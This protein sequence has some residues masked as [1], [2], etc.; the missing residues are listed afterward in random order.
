[1]RTYL[2]AALGFAVL[3]TSVLH[4]KE[5]YDFRTH[6]AYQAL[7]PEE[8]KALEQVHHDFALLWGAIDMYTEQNGGRSPEKLEQLVPLY[9]RELPTDPFATEATAAEKD[10]GTYISSKDGRG[11]R[12]RQGQDDTFILLS[13]GLPEFPYLAERG[14]VSLYRPKGLWLSG[15]QP[16]FVK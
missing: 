12:Y 14:N 5:P 7:K 4:S 16:V 6:A 3:Q 10:L 8:Q 13:V 11:Y 2:L 1:M 9:L 15:R